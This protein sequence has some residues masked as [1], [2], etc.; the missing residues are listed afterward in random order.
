MREISRPKDPTTSTPLSTSILGE[1]PPSSHTHNVDHAPRGANHQRRPIK[2]KNGAEAATCHREGSQRQLATLPPAHRYW[3]P[4]AQIFDLLQLQ[5]TGPPCLPASPFPND[6]EQHCYVCMY[7]PRRLLR[8][9][10]VLCAR[11]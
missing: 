6:T 3:F 10:G 9:G 2:A 8:V 7:P 11:M 4:S 5:R 1:T